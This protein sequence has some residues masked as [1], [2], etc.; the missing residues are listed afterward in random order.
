MAAPFL[1]FTLLL[2]RYPEGVT[3]NI[4]IEKL[5]SISDFPR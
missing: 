4:V 1:K 5:I 3:I 2:E